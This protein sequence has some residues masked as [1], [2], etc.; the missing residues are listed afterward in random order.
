M[1]DKGFLVE[2]YLILSRVRDCLGRGYIFRLRKIVL[3]ILKIFKCESCRRF[4]LVFAFN[5]TLHFEIFY[6]QHRIV[7]ESI[8]NVLWRRYHLMSPS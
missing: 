7:D 8:A 5:S 2:R 4:K 6:I 3:P 1:R